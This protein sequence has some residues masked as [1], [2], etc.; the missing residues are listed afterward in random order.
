MDLALPGHGPLIDAFQQRLDELRA[1]H[2]DRLRAVEQTVAEGA[3]AYMVCASIFPT[4]QLSPHQIRF[5]MAETLAHLEY[6]VSI[7]RL[8]RV[9]RES[10]VYQSK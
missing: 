6:L 3:T 2:D 8:E 9:E 1:H 7:G 4:E 10:I 5:A